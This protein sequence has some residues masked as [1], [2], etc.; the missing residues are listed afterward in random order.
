MS[1]SRGGGAVQRGV[2]QTA[3]G[4]APAVQPLNC[5]LWRFGLL[6][7][8]RFSARRVRARAEH[9]FARIALEALG[10]C[11]LT[12]LLEVAFFGRPVAADEIGCGCQ[13]LA[14]GSPKRVVVE[15]RAGRS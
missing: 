15:A 10:D 6:A 11:R 14:R 9:T 12:V 8:A 4:A 2:R 5:C 7:Q 1:G 13:D 3:G